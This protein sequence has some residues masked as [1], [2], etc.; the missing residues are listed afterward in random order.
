MEWRR[1]TDDMKEIN[2]II[3]KSSRL[4]KQ[5]AIGINHC[6]DNPLLFE[7]YASYEATQEPDKLSVIAG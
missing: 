7:I 1:E 6:V 3:D 4:M 5:T 2:N